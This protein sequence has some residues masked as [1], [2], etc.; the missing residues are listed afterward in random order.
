MY[1][2]PQYKEALN[3]L[4]AELEER[5][6]VQTIKSFEQ[7]VK[8]FLIS[9]DAR[10]TEH[11]HNS[12]TIVS[13]IALFDNEFGVQFCKAALPRIL[14]LTYLGGD[15]GNLLKLNLQDY[16]EEVVEVR[17]NGVEYKGEQV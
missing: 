16:M 10:R 14:H 4:R 6:V 17:D 5:H 7:T 15:H 8:R 13:S 11:V 12:Q 2:T 1:N 3:A 9:A